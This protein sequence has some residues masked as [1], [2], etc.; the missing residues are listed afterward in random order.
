MTEQNN[1]KSILAS[2]FRDSAGFLFREDGVLY[3]QVTRAG[4]E[5]YRRLMDSGL[6]A[7]LVKRGWLIDHDEGALQASG[8]TEEP[9]LRPREIPFVSWPY[10]WCFSQLKAAALLTLDIAAEALEH[11]MILRDASAYNV[12]FI[13]LRPVFIDTLSFGRYESGPWLAYRQFCQ[14]FLAPLVLMARRDVRLLGLMQRHIDGIPLDLAARLLPCSSRLSPLEFL[15]IHMHAWLQQR[16]AGDAENATGSG[17]T[18]RAAGLG[19]HQ[20]GALIDGLRRGIARIVWRPGRTAWSNYYEESNYSDESLDAKSRLVEQF[21]DRIP[22]KPEL[23]LDLGANTGRFSRISGRRAYTLACDMDAVAVEANYHSLIQ[24][25]SVLSQQILPLVLDLTNPSPS[26]GWAGTERSGFFEREHADVVLALA[27][28]HHLAVANNVPL[29]KVAR[30]FAEAGR[31]LIVEFV[32]K[33]DSQVQRLLARREDIF[34]DY[35][36]EGFERA[37]SAHFSIEAR[38]SIPGSHRTLYLMAA[39]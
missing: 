1:R 24:G 36:A 23:V 5:D 16:H 11:G 37:F 39:R 25:N 18:R 32:P 29:E 30:L 20:I 17:A 26:L 7:A 15:N 9:V 38:Q 22:G 10:E 31:C 27:L 6:Y 21:L 34:P 28:V 12:Q 19:S 3:R 14:H 33:S 8:P 4:L 2:S 35:N 13:G